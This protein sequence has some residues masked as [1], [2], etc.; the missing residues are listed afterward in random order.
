MPQLPTLPALLDMAEKLLPV[1]RTAGALTLEYYNAEADV[2]VFRKDD[3]SP[4]TEADEKSEAI[5][6]A[7]LA[8][9][10][11]PYAIVAEEQVAAQGFPEFDGT[12]FWLIDA[13]D[14]T[15][16][17]IQKRGDYT[18]NIGLV[19]AGVPALGIVYAPA[20]D[21]LWFGA[22]CPTTGERA[23]FVERDGA[24]RAPIACRAVPD[25]G[26]VVIGS[27][28]HGSAED[29]DAFVKDIKVAE[30][31]SMGSSLKFCA[32]ADGTADLYPRFG[33]TCEWD[34]GA[35]HAVLRAAGG[36]VQTFDG[37]ELPYKKPKYLNGQFIARAQ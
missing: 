31:I 30:M 36:T 37:V 19:L 33:P 1:A 35:G 9:I 2:E 20:R 8:D 18:V 23:A 34:T 24:S 7:G 28:S 21:I 4:V 26:A 29:M 6:L 16:E 10:A 17:F 5:I 15:K 11:T 13:L 3:K 25:T 22:T 32:V 14:G 12:D 27:R